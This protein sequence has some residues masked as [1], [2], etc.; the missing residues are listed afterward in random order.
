[1]TWR[2]HLRRS[3][4]PAGSCHGERKGWGMLTAGFGDWASYAPL[5]P[6]VR[7]GGLLGGCMRFIL[8]AWAQVTSRS[9]SAV[10][11]PRGWRPNQLRSNAPRSAGPCQGA[12]GGARCVPTQAP[13]RER[14]R[15][16]RLAG[17]AAADSG[18]RVSPLRDQFGA[19]SW[20]WR[21]PG[22]PSPYGLVTSELSPPTGSPAIDGAHIVGTVP[23]LSDAAQRQPCRLR[24]S[25]IV[26]KRFIASDVRTSSE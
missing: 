7:L 9:F 4:H 3:S 6:L 13:S 17:P 24:I 18:D 26:K 2:R 16:T 8:G 12:L 23:N 19:V 14:D 11:L 21:G 25:L 15:E 5:G 22:R 1:M 20:P 10:P